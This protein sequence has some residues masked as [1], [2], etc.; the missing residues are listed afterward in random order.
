[1]NPNWKSCFAQQV[2]H[3]LCLPMCTMYCTSISRTCMTV[4]QVCVTVTGMQD[5]IGI[6]F[7]NIVSHDVTNKGKDEFQRSYESWIVNGTNA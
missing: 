3:V 5:N 1:M 7:L 4:F 6:V 2:Q